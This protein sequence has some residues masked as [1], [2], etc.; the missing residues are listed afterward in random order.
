MVEAVLNRQAVART[1]YVSIR[2]YHFSDA[3]LSPQNRYSKFMDTKPFTE[4]VAICSAAS[5]ASVT[6]A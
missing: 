6:V 4:R 2:R 3:G 1:F 5:G